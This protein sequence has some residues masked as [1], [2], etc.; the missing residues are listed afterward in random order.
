MKKIILILISVL[1]FSGCTIYYELNID[2][3]LMINED[4]SFS[5]KNIT[6][7][8]YSPMQK[9]E[10]QQLLEQIKKSSIDN[11][12]ELIDSSKGNDIKLNLKKRIAFKDFKDPVLLYGK[13]VR[14]S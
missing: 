6:F 5:E 14:F 7:D 1:L 3:D 8:E 9:E 4:I 11:N 10:Y 12:Y 13:S 2:E